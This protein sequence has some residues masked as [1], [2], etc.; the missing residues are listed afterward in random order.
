MAHN[1]TPAAEENQRASSDDVGD[2]LRTQAADGE[3]SQRDAVLR[4]LLPEGSV[5]LLVSCAAKPPCVLIFC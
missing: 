2:S 4:Q 1:L 5:S 3:E